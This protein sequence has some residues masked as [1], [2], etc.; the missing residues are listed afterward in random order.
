MTGRNHHGVGR[1]SKRTAGMP[2][3]HECHRLRASARLFFRAQSREKAAALY[4]QNVHA[5]DDFGRRR[6]G[7]R[8]PGAALVGATW[9]ASG[10]RTRV[11]RA[12]RR[13]AAALQRKGGIALWLQLR[14]VGENPG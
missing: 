9:R 8:R 5:C 10:Q 1:F 14:R 7:V 13:Q 6:F 4:V 11:R 12:K 2:P 3:L